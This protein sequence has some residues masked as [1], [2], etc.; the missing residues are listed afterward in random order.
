[1]EIKTRE[2]NGVRCQIEK[3]YIEITFNH[4]GTI[5]DCGFLDHNERVDLASHL[6]EVVEDLLY[7]LKEV[8]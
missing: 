5:V 3:R 7:N 1:M 4:N 6:S 2:I 8:E